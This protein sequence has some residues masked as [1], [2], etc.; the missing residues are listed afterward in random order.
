MKSYFQPGSVVLS[1]WYFFHANFPRPSTCCMCV[2]QNQFH[3]CIVEREYCSSWALKVLL[4][5]HPNWRYQVILQLFV[6]RK[7]EKLFVVSSSCIVASA[8]SFEN[9]AIVLS[10]PLLI[11]FWLTIDFACPP[12]PSPLLWFDAKC[13]HE[14]GC[15]WEWWVFAEI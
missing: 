15:W 1:H 10:S 14:N 2:K 5:Y 6:S 9:C 4:W 13:F 11:T 3:Q 7:Y 12:A 8:K